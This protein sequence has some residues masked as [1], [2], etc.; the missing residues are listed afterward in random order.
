MRPLRGMSCSNVSC[1]WRLI[2]FMLLLVQPLHAFRMSTIVL[3]AAGMS[4]CLPVGWGHIDPLF[5]DEL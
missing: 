1:L 2:V 3:N 4:G 5:L